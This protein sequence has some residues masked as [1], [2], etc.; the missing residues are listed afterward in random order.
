MS[1]PRSFLFTAL[2]ALFCVALVVSN[3]IAGKLW[4]AP[5]GLIFTTGVWL[6]PVVYIIGDVIPEVYGLAKARQVI[7]LG[8]VLNLVAVAFFYLC[9][10]LPA[11]VFWQGQEAFEVVLGFTARLLLASFVGYL[12]GSNA[13]AYVLVA[14]KKVT[15]PTKLWTRTIGSTIVGESLDT[16][17]FVTIAFAG[18]MPVNALF[19]LMFSMA[20]FKILYEIVATPL[21]YLVINW[22]KKQ[23][24]VDQPPP[25]SSI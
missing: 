9:L 18:T 4:A 23:E 20:G 15:G 19:I 2:A 7:M 5:L 21:T 17:C 13:N 6:F 24:N 16:L 1:Q 11:P 14:M 3:I 25:I 22:V 10:Y 8:F 12:V